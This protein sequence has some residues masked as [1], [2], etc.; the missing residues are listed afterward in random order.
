MK[1]KAPV[2]KWL[3]PGLG[4]KRWLVVMALGVAFAAWGLTLFLPFELMDEAKFFVSRLIYL[5][6][7][8]RYVSPHQVGFALMGCGILLVGL[9][10]RKLNKNLLSVFA[11][12]EQEKVVDRLYQRSTLGRG[13]KT[14]ILGGGTGLSTMLRGLKKYTANIT[15]G[16]TVTD[17]GGHSGLLRKELGVIP[18][19]DLRNCLVALAE[20]EPLMKDL[21][22]YRFRSGQLK[23]HNIGNLFITALA[24]MSHSVVDAVRMSSKVLAVQGEVLPTSQ[25]MIKLKALFEDGTQAVGETAIVKARKRISKLYI[26]PADARPTKALVDA[27]QDAE[28]V[29]LGP[30]SLFTSVVPHFLIKEMRLAIVESKAVKVYICNV[31]TQP[32]ETDGFTASDHIQTVLGYLGEDR[33]DACL[34]N[35]KKPSPEILAYYEQHDQHFVEADRE[36]I[37]KLPVYPIYSDFIDQTNL[38]RHDPEK[39][40]A[41]LFEVLVQ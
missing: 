20:A 29:L 30:G 32:G 16:V 19:G 39:T 33:L 38:V 21:M 31:M 37:E 40:L 3:Y 36:N 12:E 27:V 15:V 34:I 18:P 41:K 26:D 7:G 10:V 13:V 5:F 25:E 28:L 24:D 1:S 4:V 35:V 23:G 8:H 11:P 9:S 17:D 6:T 14:V 22:Q 2:L